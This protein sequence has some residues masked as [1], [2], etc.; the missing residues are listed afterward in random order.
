[1]ADSGDTLHLGQVIKETGDFGNFQI[2][3]IIYNQFGVLIL[4]WSMLTMSNTAAVPEWLCYGSAIGLNETGSWNASNVC[5]I[6]GSSCA[7]IEFVDDMKT[8]VSEVR[9]YTL[10]PRLRQFVYSSWI[11][12]NKSE[13]TPFVDI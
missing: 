3:M 7:V 12:T 4:N 1:M 11:L 10:F 5:K 2:L 13:R 9:T 6:N 8:A